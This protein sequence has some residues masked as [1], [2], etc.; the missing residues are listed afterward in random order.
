MARAW[1]M[2]IL[3]RH[4]YAPVKTSVKLSLRCGLFAGASEHRPG[5][6]L[7]CESGVNAA[8][9]PIGMAGHSRNI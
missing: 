8:R 9:R 7:D 2:R 1:M 6:C 5:R 3:S 4:F